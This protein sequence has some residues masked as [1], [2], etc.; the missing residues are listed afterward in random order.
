MKCNDALMEYKTYLIVEK[1]VSDNTLQAYIRDIFYFNCFIDEKFEIK[2]I[3]KIEKEHIRLYLES[4]NSLSSLTVSRKIV[5]LRNYFKFL[6]KE[7]IIENNL[8]TVFELPKSPKKLPQVLSVEEMNK[9]L[10]NIEMVD[11]DSARNRAMIEL[12]YAS[13]IRVSEL[14]N[15]QLSQI[16]LKMMYLK[17]I[18]KGDKERL[19]PLNQYV[20][21]I[22][23]DYIINY[24]NPLLDFKSNNYLFFNKKLKPVSRENFYKILKKAAIRA[25]ITKKVSP[26][27][28]RHSYAT[29]LLENDADLRSIQELLGHSDISTTTIYTHITNSKMIDDYNKFHIRAN[30]DI[31]EDK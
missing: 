21:Q 11:F 28:I 14:V 20:C 4:L 7:E 12:L 27:T 15:I 3:E 25:G 9:L 5:S 23:N 1:G 30:K 2:Q 24:R 6:V 18:G 19:I 8:M 16:N 13:G 31:K 10:N 22:I 29:H 26:H 17:V